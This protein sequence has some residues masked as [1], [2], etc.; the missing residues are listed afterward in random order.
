MYLGDKL[1][2]EYGYFF[3][4]ELSRDRRQFLRS[5]GPARS[6]DIRVFVD[7]LQDMF[8]PFPVCTQCD[9]AVRRPVLL[10]LL[11]KLGSR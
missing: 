3:G 11:S 6:D 2:P 9:R 10:S 7:V 5:F 8:V 4:H 1:A